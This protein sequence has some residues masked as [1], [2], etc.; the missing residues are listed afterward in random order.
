MS[1]ED[2]VLVASRH[3]IGAAEVDEGRPRRCTS[4][5]DLELEDDEEAADAD[6][7]EEVAGRWGAIGAR[8]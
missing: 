3:K 7:E 5:V 6:E 2:L 8:E 1:G 4:R